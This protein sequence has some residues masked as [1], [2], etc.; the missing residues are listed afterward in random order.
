MSMQK[1]WVSKCKNGKKDVTLLLYIF[2]N[3]SFLFMMFWCEVHTIYILTKI[4]QLS[5]CNFTLNYVFL[6]Y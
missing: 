4:V 5:W 2:K 1:I 6:M 3:V